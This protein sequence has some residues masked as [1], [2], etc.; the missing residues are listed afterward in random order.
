L[1]LPALLLKLDDLLEEV[2]PI[3]PNLR[4]DLVHCGLVLK[5]DLLLLLLEFVEI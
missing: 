3:S 2:Q 5:V 1:V 4:L